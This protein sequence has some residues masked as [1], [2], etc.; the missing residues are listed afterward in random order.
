[1]LAFHIS[2]QPIISVKWIAKLSVCYRQYSWWWSGIILWKICIHRYN[3]TN[4]TLNGMVTMW[5]IWCC[6]HSSLLL[7]YWMQ[8]IS[9]CFFV[10]SSLIKTKINHFGNTLTTKFTQVTELAVCL[11]RKF[12]RLP[13]SYKSKMHDPTIQ[14]FQYSNWFHDIVNSLVVYAK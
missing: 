7:L 12:K 2:F 14:H 5:Y 4:T 13:I 9:F 11:H 3:M 10:I 6:L 1:M 8:F